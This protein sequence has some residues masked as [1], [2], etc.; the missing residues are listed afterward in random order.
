MENHDSVATSVPPVAPYPSGPMPYGRPGP[1]SK[2][3]LLAAFWSALIPGLGHVYVG[4]YQRAMIIFVVWVGIFSSAVG[5][6]GSELGVL[7]PMTVFTWLFNIFDAYRQATLAMWGE[8]EEIPNVRER[9]KSG[10][11]FGIALFV[12]GLYGLLRKYF[13]IDLSILLDHWYLVVM[14]AGGWLIWQAWSAS[15]S[16]GS[17]AS[18]GG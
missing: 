1:P 18:D 5:A 12:I 8:P 9:G 10:L 17:S 16:A 7:V 14:A 13:E 6:E 15:K 2:S 3:P 4:I 11:T